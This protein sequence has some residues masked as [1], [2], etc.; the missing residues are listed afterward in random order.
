MIPRVIPIAPA[1]H[2]GADS[3]AEGGAAVNAAM[4]AGGEIHGAVITA[5]WHRH[6][7]NLNEWHTK[8]HGVC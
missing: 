3:S 8:L 4:I 5:E 2:P 7:R 1:G 6:K